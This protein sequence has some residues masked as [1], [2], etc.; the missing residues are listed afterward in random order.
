MPD[1]QGTEF[2]K[3]SKTTQKFV[4]SE[5]CEALRVSHGNLEEEA[6]LEL[7]LI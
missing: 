7:G 5:D 6:R 4:L 3:N 2:E 1:D